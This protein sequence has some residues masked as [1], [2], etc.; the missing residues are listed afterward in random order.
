MPSVPVR[1][2]RVRPKDVEANEVETRCSHRAFLIP[3][4][5][6]CVCVRKH[7]TLPR[8]D[9]RS[10]HKE[11]KMFR[12]PDA[13]RHRGAGPEVEWDLVPIVVLSILYERNLVASRFRWWPIT[14]FLKDGFTGKGLR[15][16]NPR[17]VLN[18]CEMVQRCNAF[19]I[20]T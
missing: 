4:R 9:L 19:P 20:Q 10:D 5:L 11:T 18:A 17:K 7:N 15:S 2:S 12:S 16:R 3:Q 14:G 1:R 13:P 8:R 6:G